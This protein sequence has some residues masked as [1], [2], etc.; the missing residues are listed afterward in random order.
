MMLHDALLSHMLSLRN[1]LQKDTAD[2][3]TGMSTQHP[4]FLR[5]GFKEE[6]SLGVAYRIKKGGE[7]C[8]DPSCLAFH[9]GLTMES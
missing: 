4:S 1:N 2:H 3:A 9:F 7:F 8:L 5:K 6:V